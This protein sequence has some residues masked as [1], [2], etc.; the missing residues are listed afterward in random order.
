MPELPLVVSVILNT[1]RREDTLACL[2]TLLLGDYLNHKALV[3]DNACTD[4]SNEAI[5]TRFPQV[6]ILT[7]EENKGYAGNN[8]V[9]IKAALEWGAE[10][11]FLLN[12]DVLL[13]KDTLSLLVQAAQLEPQT[14]AIGPLV[15]HADDPQVI[16]SAGGRLDAQWRAT[17]IGQNQPDQG[18][19]STARNVDWISGCAILM[20]RAVIDQVGAIDER[21][22]Y[23]WE[24]TEWCLRAARAGWKIR[25][26]PRAHLW[27]KGVQQNYT[28]GPNVTY[29]QTR[30]RFLALSK[31]SAPL[32]VWAAAY[33][34]AGRTLLAWSLRPKWRAKQDHRD[35]LWDGLLDFWHGRWGMR[36]QQH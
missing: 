7:L 35:A 10:W 2:D 20:K 12:E 36:A 1:N 30:N 21:F 15:Y 27:H 25:I 34:S 28:P 29:Y 23:Y 3:L 16:Q 26:E 19:Y 5:R 13:A 22:F 14:G 11:V 8:N 24:E 17:H 9:G 33:F 4:G 6:E 31:H 32:F 18:Q